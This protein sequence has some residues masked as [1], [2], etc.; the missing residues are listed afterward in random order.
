MSK[1]K[2]KKRLKEI[3]QAGII[4]LA[5][6]G[7]FEFWKHL[8]TEKIPLFGRKRELFDYSE[9][10]F[11]NIL[12]NEVLF[13][14][15]FFGYHLLLICTIVYGENWF[16]KDIGHILFPIICIFLSLILA[17]HFLLWDM[18]EENAWYKSE[19]KILAISI[20]LIALLI[21]WWLLDF[22]YEPIVCRD[23]FGKVIDCKQVMNQLN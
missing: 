7:Y 4:Y 1:E 12:A 13:L 19:S 11:G 16:Y 18:Y 10:N 3:F 5:L 17:L 6:I 23:V 21:I 22:Y 15:I 8:F 14:I 2:E 20:D 9:R